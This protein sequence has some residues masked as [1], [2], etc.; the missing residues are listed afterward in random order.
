MESLRTLLFL[1]L[2]WTLS[3]CDSYYNY[4]PLIS[5]KEK[6]QYAEALKGTYHGIYLR[7]LNTGIGGTESGWT[8]DTIPEAV[9]EVEDYSTSRVLFRDVP[10]TELAEALGTQ[11]ICEQVIQTSPIRDIVCRYRFHK[12]DGDNIGFYL[13]P[14]PLDFSATIDGVKR[15]VRIHLSNDNNVWSFSVKAP[16]NSM[17]GYNQRLCVTSIEMDGE[18][19]LQENSYTTPYII[20]FKTPLE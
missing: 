16:Y 8:L 5:E 1:A 18:I 19:I 2:A 15:R 6:M 12:I 4:K 3:A 13:T 14:D 10:F 20:I 17:N 7:L 11:T 9:M